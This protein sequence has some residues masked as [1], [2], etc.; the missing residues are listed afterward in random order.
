VQTK[1]RALAR[2]GEHDD[3]RACPPQRE[4]RFARALEDPHAIVQHAEL[5]D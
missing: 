1:C 5:V 3:R 4:Q 2:V